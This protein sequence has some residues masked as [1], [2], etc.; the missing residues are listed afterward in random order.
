MDPG[1]CQ[2]TGASKNNKGASS[3]KGQQEQ[4]K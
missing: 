3:N 4:D 2:L 1:G